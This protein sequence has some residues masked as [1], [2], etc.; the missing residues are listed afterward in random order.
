MNEIKVYWSTLD[1]HSESGSHQPDPRTNLQKKWAGHTVMFCPSWKKRWNNVYS[2]DSKLDMDFVYNHVEKYFVIQQQKNQ[3]QSIHTR[4]LPS[5]YPFLGKGK[6]KRV[7]FNMDYP[8]MMVPEVD[9]L[10][11]EISH[12]FQSHSD[13]ANSVDVCPG[14]FNLGT[15]P[16]S[17]GYAF[18]LRDPSKQEYKIR[19]GDPLY[20]IRFK[21]NKKIKMI[22]FYPTTKIRELS[23]ACTSGQ[24]LGT[25]EKYYDN[26]KKWRIKKLLMKEIK[27]QL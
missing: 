26:Y 5:A 24:N 12:P 14:E 13:W 1:M 3:L 11:I 18:S 21:T 27:G 4:Y 6:A 23:K 17:F 7:F 10:E 8:M 9:D 22:P 2:I 15:Y 20:Y 16:K 25:L 19:K